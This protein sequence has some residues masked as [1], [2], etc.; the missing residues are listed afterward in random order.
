M[1]WRRTGVPE[2]ELAENAPRGVALGDVPIVLVRA[3]GAVRAVQ[4]SCPHIGG[5]LADGTVDLGKLS[6]PLHGATFD[7]ATGA[8]RADPFGVA[9]PEGAVEPLRVYP[10][11][12]ADGE[13]EVDL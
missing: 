12:V 5:D 8:V 7:L 3:A 1:T 10:V 13:V 4:G 2:A 6:C 9:P 11:R